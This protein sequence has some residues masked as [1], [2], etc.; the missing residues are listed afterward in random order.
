MMEE[1]ADKAVV[2]G[3]SGNRR[4]TRAI[5]DYLSISPGKDEV[6]KFSEGN[7]FVRVLENV[8]G[9][10]VYVVQSTAFPANDNFMELLFWLGRAQTCKRR[11]SHRR[12]PLLQLC[13]GGQEGRAPGLHP[14]PR[15][16]RRHRSGGSRPRRHPRPACPQIQGF[17]RVPADDLYAA[18]VLCERIV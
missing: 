16:C 12:H 2:F 15:L 5:C 4:L 3:G 10:R 7:L 13:Q 1:D 14:R 8:R 9:R 6:I 11:V 18:P 17:F